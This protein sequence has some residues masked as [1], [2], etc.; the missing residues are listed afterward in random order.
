MLKTLKG[1]NYTNRSYKVYNIEG[2]CDSCTAFFFLFSFWPLLPFLHSCMVDAKIKVFVK[3]GHRGKKNA[4]KYKR[5]KKE[6]YENVIKE[7]CR[8][9]GDL[10]STNQD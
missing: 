5:K 8:E 4:V 3:I 2:H 1:L 10:K 6:G 9:D 7:M